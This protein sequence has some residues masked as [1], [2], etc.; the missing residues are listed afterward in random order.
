M[1][2]HAHIATAPPAAAQRSRHPRIFYPPTTAALDADGADH[3]PD[4][5]VEST[6]V[7]CGNLA[8][9][10][11]RHRRVS[12]SYNVNNMQV[13]Y[14]IVTRCGSE[15]RPPRSEP[16]IGEARFLRPA[17]HHGFDDPYLAFQTV[18]GARTWRTRRRVRVLQRLF[19]VE[20]QPF[21]Y[22]V[23]R[24]WS[25][26]QGPLGHAPLPAVLE[27]YFNISAAESQDISVDFGQQGGMIKSRATSPN[28]ATRS[29]SPSESTATV[30]TPI[31]VTV[32]SRTRSTIRS[33]AASR[34]GSIHEDDRGEREDVHQRDGEHGGREASSRRSSP[35]SAR[36]NTTTRPH[37]QS[38]TL[39]DAS[40]ECAHSLDFA[41]GTILLGCSK[42]Q[43][44]A[45]DTGAAASASAPPVAT[46][47]AS[48]SSMRRRNLSRRTG[49]PA[50]S[51][52][53]VASRS[54][55]TRGTARMMEVTWR[56]VR[57]GRRSVVPGR[58]QIEGDPLRKDG[59]LFLRQGRRADRPKSRSKTRRRTPSICSGGKYLRGRRESKREA[60][61]DV[62]VHEEGHA[63]GR[64]RW[65][66]AAG[67]RLA[68]STNKKNDFY[69]RNRIS[70]R[71]APQKGGEK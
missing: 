7:Y 46:S 2:N 20:A 22:T 43:P 13:A 5:S 44:A 47:V 39:R 24:M 9:V 66:R 54:R 67:R 48:A 8:R 11:A 30:T 65:S 55:V 45:A 29:G 16:R 17:R 62:L 56:E 33:P 28:G 70:R 21:A 14:G 52:A 31:T 37:R 23:Q 25:N 38:V 19:Y 61:D 34:S 68:D 60:H 32:A 36:R 49:V 57:Q 71:T 4:L 51:A 27:T 41:L 64:S 59:R 18:L 63:G 12:H 40:S 1:A 69:W 42:R 58:E 26:K 6:V 15:T 10:P 3:L 53:S 35:R 50:G